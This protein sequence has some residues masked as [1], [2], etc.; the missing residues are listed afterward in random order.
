MINTS[1]ANKFLW[2]N[3]TSFT[4]D[5]KI[6]VVE[7]IDGCGKTTLSMQLPALIHMATGD[8]SCIY[9][10]PGATLWGEKIREILKSDTTHK[11]HP[12]T[13]HLLM[14]ASRID[15]MLTLQ[16]R[17]QQ[18]WAIL[19][20][21]EDSSWAYQGVRGVRHDQIYYT[22]LGYKDLVKPDLTIFLDVDPEIAKERIELSKGLTGMEF[23]DNFS[24][25]FFRRIRSA[26][27]QRVEGNRGKY[28]VVD[29]NQ[30][31][32]DV[33]NFVANSLTFKNGN[34]HGST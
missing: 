26:F 6:I 5:N 11:M 3:P 25:A 10:Q 19:D 13:E 21:H 31:E 18:E 16:E 29:A 7:G 12:R 9:R 33:L 14:E 15:L 32:E 24:I 34:S 30:P 1:L 8:R 2:T 22:Q 27:H 23:Y 17:D 20:R 4:Y 28:L